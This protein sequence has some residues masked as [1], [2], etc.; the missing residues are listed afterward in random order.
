MVDFQDSEEWQLLAGYA[1]GELTLEELARFNEL[2]A[3]YPELAVEVSRLQAT[4]ALLPL[5]LPEVLPPSALSSQ[6]SQ[7]ARRVSTTPASKSNHRRTGRLVS[8]GILGSV[9]ACFLF[10]FGL[11]NFHLH[12]DLITAQAELTRYKEAIALLRQPRK[13]LLTLRGTSIKPTASGSLLIVPN[14]TAV[15]TAQNLTPLPKG[16]VYHLWAVTDGQKMNCGKFN[17]DSQGRVLLQFPPDNLRP[18]TSS[19]LITVEPSQKVSQPTGE[20]VMTGSLSL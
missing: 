18:N 17:P 11:Y 6:I 4:L 16:Q 14:Q 20:I 7:A 5:A 12:Q 9:A 3:S 13:R 1:F 10:G 2:L 15:L 19:V 8:L